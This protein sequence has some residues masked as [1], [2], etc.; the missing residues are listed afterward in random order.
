MKIV[1]LDAK[2]LGHV[3]NLLQLEEFGE[4]ALYQNTTPEKRLEHLQDAQIAVTNKVVLD[5]E[6]LE[7]CFQLKMICIAATGANNVDLDYAKEKGIVVKNAE[8]YSSTSVAQ[9]TMA[10]ILS[11]LCRPHYYDQYVKKGDYS[12]NDTFTHIGHD[13]F[14]LEGKVMGIIGMGNIGRKMAGIAKGFGMEVIYYSTSGQNNE[15]PYRQCDLDEL[16]RNSDIISIH[17]PLNDRTQ[18]LIDKKAIQKMKGN[19]IIANSGRGGIVNETDLVEALNKNLIRGAAIDVYTEE[20]LPGDH[21]YMNVS[22]PE[23]II[24]TPHVTWASIESRTMLVDI[25]ADNIRDFIH[26]HH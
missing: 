26:Q 4:L 18:N 19:A 3:P 15:Q 1:V 2:T 17:A 12:K 25:V 5:K 6:I 8:N 23:K 21:V 14:Q 13:F 9:F 24:L 22:E 7:K 16:L 11:L 10:N 20:P